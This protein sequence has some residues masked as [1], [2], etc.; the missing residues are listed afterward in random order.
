MFRV[1]SRDTT[2]GSD[3]SL[4][5][6]SEDTGYSEGEEVLRVTARKLEIHRCEYPLRLGDMGNRWGDDED[7]NVSLHAVTLA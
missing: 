7:P 3:E 1:W 2:N 6:I 5:A 4:Q